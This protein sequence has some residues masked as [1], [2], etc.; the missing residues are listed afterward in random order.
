MSY[1]NDELTN[2]KAS[3]AKQDLSV[4]GYRVKAHLGVSLTSSGKS[5]QY[6]EL[7]EVAFLVNSKC[8]ECHMDGDLALAGGPVI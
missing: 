5:W 2:P 1:I 4:Q 6:G 8:P 3:L 7:G